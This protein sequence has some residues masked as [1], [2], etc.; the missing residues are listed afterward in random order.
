VTLALDLVT[1]RR[2]PIVMD[3]SGY[4]FADDVKV[5]QVVFHDG[6]VWLRFHDPHRW[7]SF[8]RGSR[9]VEFRLWDLLQRLK[10]EMPILA[11]TLDTEAI[12]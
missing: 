7:R 2:L 9:T 8:E 5:A 11:P 3:E 10:T 12:P 4:I 6:D 1:L